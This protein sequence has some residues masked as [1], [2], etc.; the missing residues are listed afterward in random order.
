MYEV[1]ENTEGVENSDIVSVRPVPYAR[2][3]LGTSVPLVWTPTLLAGSVSNVRW[4][5]VM[6]NSTDFQLFRDNA[7]VGTFSTGVLITRTELSF[8]VTPS[9]Y[10]AGDKWEFVTYSYN[11]FVSLD[12]PSII[13][14]AVGDIT[15]NATGG[16]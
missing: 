11:N 9:A 12:E 2:P 16:L 14:S 3:V 13:V 7:F 8:T 6:T 4:R 10:T 1:I 15:V 5:I